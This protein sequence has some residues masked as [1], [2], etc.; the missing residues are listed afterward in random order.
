MIDRRDLVNFENIYASGMYP[1]WRFG[2]AKS[3][4]GIS[5]LIYHVN[6]NALWLL[7]IEL[8]YETKFCLLLLKMEPINFNVFFLF[9][10]FKKMKR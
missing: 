4:E 10:F 9:R 1:V 6:I 2:T 3:K 5:Q 8:K 7:F